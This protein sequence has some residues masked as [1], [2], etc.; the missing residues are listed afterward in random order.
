MSGTRRKRWLGMALAATIAL[1]VGAPVGSGAP[2]PCPGNYA[3]RAV[4]P[5]D[6][7][8]DVDLNGNGLVCA[9]QGSKADVA[10]FKDDRVR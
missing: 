6:Q 9:Y 1:S 10:P 7:S 3:P 5:E 2:N 4:A 8:V